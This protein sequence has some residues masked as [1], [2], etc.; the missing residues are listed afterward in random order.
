MNGKKFVV[1]KNWL[2]DKKYIY[3]VKEFAIF[4]LFFGYIL[5]D[6]KRKEISFDDWIII[7]F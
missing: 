4:S 3:I 6:R 1:I 5:I 2:K 7:G